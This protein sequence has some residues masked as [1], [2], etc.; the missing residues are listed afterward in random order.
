MEMVYLIVTLISQNLENVL[1]GF[2]VFRTLLRPEVFETK[3]I[4]YI[5][6]VHD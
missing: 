4:D 3:Y 1:P 2:D 5:N 6:P